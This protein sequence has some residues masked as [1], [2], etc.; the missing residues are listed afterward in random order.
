MASICLLT[1]FS[2]LRSSFFLPRSYMRSNFPTPTNTLPWKGAMA[3]GTSSTGVC[4]NSK[5]KWAHYCSVHLINND[6][7]S[8]EGIKRTNTVLEKLWIGK[9][10][11]TKASFSSQKLTSDLKSYDHARQ[12]CR[13]FYSLPTNRQKGR[14]SSK[15]K[16]I[17][18]WTYL[19]YKLQLFT[20]SYQ[21][22][23]INVATAYWTWVKEHVSCHAH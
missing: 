4:R 7:Y 21:A 3:R 23:G 6:R 14:R 1:L 18:P 5:S 2:H 9:K 17:S 16:V 12:I 13:G 22:V 20:T 11:N 8:R 15:V 19:M 10:T